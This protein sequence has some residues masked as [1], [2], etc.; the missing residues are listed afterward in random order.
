M[1]IPNRRVKYHYCQLEIT[2][3]IQSV[4]AFAISQSSH[5]FNVHLNWFYTDLI[6]IRV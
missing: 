2:M 6:H 5:T 3:K 4:H 1:L